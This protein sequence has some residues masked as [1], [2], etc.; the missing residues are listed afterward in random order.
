[1]LDEY[2]KVKLN[3][4][5]ESISRFTRL[6]MGTVSSGIQRMKRSVKRYIEEHENGGM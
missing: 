1:V 5:Y 6:P 2:M 4:S 3:P